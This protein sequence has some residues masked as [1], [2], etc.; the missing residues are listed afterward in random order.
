MPVACRKISR[1]TARSGCCSSAENFAA[2]EW[3]RPSNSHL[4]LADA[5]TTSPSKANAQIAAFMAQRPQSCGA[6]Q[7][8]ILPND[9]SA[10]R[11][12][13]ETLS[14]FDFVPWAAERVRFARCGRRR[15]RLGF[16]AEDRAATGGFL[17]AALQIVVGHAL[18]I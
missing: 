1:G 10:F 3:I 16:L 6:R 18:E 7:C 15:Q 8:A 13:E 12:Q 9:F 17:L 14:G 2:S 5:D 11:G 4:S